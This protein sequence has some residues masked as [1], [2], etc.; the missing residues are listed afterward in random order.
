MAKAVGKP[1]ADAG[2]EEG[3]PDWKKPTKA[4]YD[5]QDQGRLF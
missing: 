2:I 3:F 5:E 4:D 1:L